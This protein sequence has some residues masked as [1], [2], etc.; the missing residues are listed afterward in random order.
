MT[1]IEDNRIRMLELKIEKVTAC[2]S[3]LERDIH[4]LIEVAE[5]KPERKSFYHMDQDAFLAWFKNAG[6]YQYDDS[7]IWHASRKEVRE[8]VRAVL[9]DIN[10]ENLRHSLW[11]EEADAIEAIRDLVEEPKDTQPP[12]PRGEVCCKTDIDETCQ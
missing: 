4:P 5:P 12:L 3:Q 8:Q 9:E 10:V 11:T 1:A 6:D 2:L 7:A